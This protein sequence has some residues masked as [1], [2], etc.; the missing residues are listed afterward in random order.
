MFGRFIRN[1]SNAQKGRKL[2]LRDHNKNRSIL[3]RAGSAK[4]Q[5]CLIRWSDKSGFDVVL[6]RQVQEPSD[7][8]EHY[9]AYQIDFNGKQRKGVVLLRGKFPFTDVNIAKT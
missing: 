8:I 6:E 4:P 5:F 2:F 9:K 7:T 3:E 1:S